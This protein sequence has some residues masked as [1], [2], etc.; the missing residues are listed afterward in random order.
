MYYQIIVT[1]KSISNK[2]TT[3][4]QSEKKTTMTLPNL[5]KPLKDRSQKTLQ[6]ESLSFYH[7]L[8]SRLF[9]LVFLLLFSHLFSRLPLE[10]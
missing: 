5:D 3:Y 9:F 2:A 10:S 4:F 1:T 6:D 7:P 8:A